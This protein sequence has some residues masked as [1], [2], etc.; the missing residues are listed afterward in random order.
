MPGLGR[1]FCQADRRHRTNATGPLPPWP[2]MRVYCCFSG[3][4][5]ASP[6]SRSPPL[7]SARFPR[8]ARFLSQNFCTSAGFGNARAGY[9][10]MYVRTCGCTRVCDARSRD[11][12]IPGCLD[13]SARAGGESR[14]IHLGGGGG[15]EVCVCV[16]R[17][18][19]AK[20]RG[21]K[22]KQADNDSSSII[23]SL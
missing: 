22:A 15:G 21:K 7:A 20:R 14:R 8:P 9:A 11:P 6:G 4:A 12:L 5:G 10:L 16:L 2:T 23:A 1:G 3:S 18:Q 13:L 19:T 17:R